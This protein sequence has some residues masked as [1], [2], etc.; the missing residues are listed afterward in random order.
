[1]T[2]KL[3]RQGIPT[4]L[5]EEQF[6]QF[7]LPYLTVGRRRSASKLTSHAIFNYML[8]LLYIGCPWKELPIQKDQ[9]GRPEIHY[10]RIYCVFR[11]WEAEGCIAA[12]FTSSVAKLHQ[13]DLL[14]TSIIHGD[15]TTTA[16]K[17]RRQHWV[18]RTQEGQRRQGRGLLLP[19]LQRHRSVCLGTRESKRIAHAARG[20]T[21]GDQDRSR[22]GLVFARNNRQP[23]RGL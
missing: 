10:T 20:I 15:G 2:A 9:S 1:M 23:G 14:D 4:K 6:N 16:A 7:V 19:E 21:T 5:S 3:K 18:Q 22:A 13:D 8:H 17:K 12:I 11:R